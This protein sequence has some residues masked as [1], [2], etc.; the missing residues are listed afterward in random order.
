MIVAQTPQHVVQND[1]EQVNFW[2]STSAIV[3]GI[4]VIVALIVTRGWSK[5]IHQKRDEVVR[6]EKE[7]NNK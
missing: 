4:V 3:I 7:E 1:K 5:R 6:K 2:E